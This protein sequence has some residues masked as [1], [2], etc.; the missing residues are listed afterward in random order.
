MKYLYWGIAIGGGIIVASIAY[1]ALSGPEELSAPGG[2]GSTGPQNPGAWSATDIGQGVGS[3]LGPLA[4]ALRGSGR[5][6]KDGDSA[7]PTDTTDDPA[8]AAGK[9]GV[10]GAAAGAGAGVDSGT[11]SA[12]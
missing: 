10:N 3:L 2:S 4:A 5:S 1:K 6:G 9:R 7:S 12:R 11:L 8:V